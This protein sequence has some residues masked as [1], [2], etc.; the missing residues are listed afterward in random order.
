MENA[1]FEYLLRLGDDS[2]IL[3]HRL[4]EWCGHGP[5][6]EEDIAL[7]NLSLDLIG[8]ATSIFDYAGKVEG[9]GRS[10]DD[11]AFLR[12][13]K[14]YRN[15]LLVERPNVDFGV[16]I[17]RQFLFDAY[18]KPLFERLVHS[19]DEMIA[20]IAAKSLKETKYHLRH[21]SEWVI[22]LGDGTEESHNRIQDALNELWKYAAEIFYED[23]VD[24]ELKANGVL[25]DMDSLKSD[26][27]TI[28]HAVL[29]EA[30]LTIPDNNW[31]QEGGR[32]GLHTEHLGF[33]LAELQYMQRAYPNMEW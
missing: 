10:E 3:G 13:D 26:W 11:L 30:T 23:A 8:Q 12:F 7:T 19:S 14:D 1:L 16:T 17:M 22:R 4:S 5:V 2:L 24:A 6:L 25:P 31:K 32:K 21:S 15:L 18:R 20:A 9:K 29:E 33:I 28:V 27:D